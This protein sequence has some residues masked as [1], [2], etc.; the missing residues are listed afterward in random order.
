MAISRQGKLAAYFLESEHNSM[1]NNVT[2]TV[3]LAVG[4]FSILNTEMGIVGILPMVSAKYGID[5]VQAGYLVSFFA[6][7]V[8]VAGPVM[9]LLCS[10]LDRRK[11][12][13]YVLG[14][15]TLCNITAVLAPSFDIMLA[16]R[17]VPSFFHPVYCAMAF[18][19]A[20][21]TAKPGREAQ[22]VAYIN[23]G[24]AGGMVIGVPI[25]N[26]LATHF[27]LEAAL[28]FFAILTGVCL[29]LSWLKVP[30]MPAKNT[31]SYGRQFEVLKRP[32][33][34]AAIIAVILLNGAVF[35]VFNYLAEYLDKVTVSGAQWSFVLLFAYGIMNLFGSWLGGQLLSKQP[36]LSVCLFPLFLLLVYTM[37]YSGGDYLPW[38]AVII[39]LW[40][41]L[42]GINGNI[43]QYWLARAVPEAPDFSNGLF[44]TAAN[45]G[46]MAGTFLSGI[47][48][49]NFGLVYVMF[50]GICLASFGFFLVLCQTYFY[51]KRDLIGK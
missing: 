8:A 45:I 17:V 27:Q 50:G 49:R 35:G 13:I 25:S 28:G 3:I 38:I 46:C 16:A 5:I 14:I 23:M 6:F 32:M 42:G 44:L 2:L 19:V 21:A 31:M 11:V 39:I 10:K 48:I 37:M 34:W 18:S 9:P 47:F 12:M 33:T 40:G 29:V 22:A 20:T 24:V 36:L 51:R 1:G 4:V 30:S 15:F 41:T 7:G 43:N 26:F